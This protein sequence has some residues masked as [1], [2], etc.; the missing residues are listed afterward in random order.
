LSVRIL[1][2]GGTKFIGPYVVEELVSFG[3][4]VTVY[5]RGE[6]EPPL[7]LGVRHVHSPAAAMPV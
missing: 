1:I 3:H 2:I 7:P 6:H 5:H 4:D